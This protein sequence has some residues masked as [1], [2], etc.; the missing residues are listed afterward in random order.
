MLT[1]F[2]STLIFYSSLLWKQETIV[3]RYF[4]EKFSK[5]EVF[6]SNFFPIET[7]GIFSS[8]FI[9]SPHFFSQVL[10]DYPTY[11][12]YTIHIVGILVLWQKFKRKLNKVFTDA[13]NEENGRERNFSLWRFVEIPKKLKK[14]DFGG[15]YGLVWWKGLIL[16]VKET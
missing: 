4:L 16:G 7:W 2:N 12:L 3:W 11:F 15:V 14:F 8:N 13:R 6:P 1:F 10:F 9:S 5:K